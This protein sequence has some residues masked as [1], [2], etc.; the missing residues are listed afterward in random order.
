MNSS[1]AE[2]IV[3]FLER[4]AITP[5]LVPDLSR[6]SIINRVDIYRRPVKLDLSSLS[7]LLPDWTL[8]APDSTPRY[9]QIV[10]EDD[11]DDMT[12]SRIVEYKLTDRSQYDD[13]G[14]SMDE[15]VSPPQPNSILEH[16]VNQVK[17]VLTDES[18]IYL[19]VDLDRTDRQGLI[20]AIEE[21]VNVS[22]NLSNILEQVYNQVLNIVDESRR[23]FY[24]AD[25]DQISGSYVRPIFVGTSF[26]LIDIDNRVWRYDDGILSLTDRSSDENQSIISMTEYDGHWIE[27]P[28]I[29]ISE[30]MNNIN[31]KNRTYPISPNVDV[32]IIGLE[33]SDNFIWIFPD[34]ISVNFMRRSDGLYLRSG[35]DLVRIL[36][37]VDRSDTDQVFK[38]RYDVEESEWIPEEIA[39][40]VD[41]V[42]KATNKILRVV[43]NVTLAELVK[44]L[45]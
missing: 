6:A 37:N 39:D 5:G 11:I 29:S 41:E 19:L 28:T 8:I 15:Y 32:P 43:E 10:G 34:S 2:Q 21:S 35:E 42:M 12:V 27:S 30:F 44:I 4:T 3:S 7:D 26:Y 20:D 33:L 9:E 40:D 13:L 31:L 16:Q 17:I 36:P 24:R 14:L 45:E 38:Y 18:S 23:P 1:I 22:S 25:A